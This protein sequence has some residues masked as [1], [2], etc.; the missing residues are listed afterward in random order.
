MN[1]TLGID[2]IVR[3]WKGQIQ[4]R[5]SI[6][7]R[8][9]AMIHRFLDTVKCQ[10]SMSAE[11]IVQY[12]AYLSKDHTAYYVNA[13]IS[14]IR[15]F[16]RWLERMNYHKD[17]SVG[18]RHLK[19]QRWYHKEPLSEQQ[20]TDLMRV[21]SG[22]SP[23]AKRDRAIIMLMLYCGLRCNEVA[24]LDVGDIDIVD[25]VYVLRLLRK[26]HQSK[27]MRIEMIP[28]LYDAIEECLVTRDA[29]D[30]EPIIVSHNR[31]YRSSAVRMSAVSISMIVKG[32]LRKAGMDDSRYT[33]HSLRHTFGTML[34]REGLPLSTVSALMGHTNTSVTMVY[35]K[36]EEQRRLIIDRPIE[37]ARKYITCLYNC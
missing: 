34:L 5:K 13:N 32:Y 6:Q 3:Q 16:F 36:Q 10:R 28:E 2:E 1:T 22:D 15:S 4:Q 37:K 29:K 24:S 33:A 7:D 25:G 20:V 9:A 23:K 27:D 21:V 11:D 8:E 12:I 19:V 18:I 26:G 14:V 35:V 30:D 31:A 17:V